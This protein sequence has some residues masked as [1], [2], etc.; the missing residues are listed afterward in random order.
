MSTLEQTARPQQGKPL[1]GDEILTNAIALADRVRKRNL[2][3][4]YDELRMLPADIVQE[5]REAGIMRM[6]MPRSWGG[7]EMTIM[8][9]ARVIEELAKADASIAWCSFIWAD[10]GVYPAYLDD[11][12]AR[13]LYPRLDM[14]TSGWVYPVGTAKRVT[15]GYEISGRWM[16]GSGINHCDWVVSGCLVDDVD[17]D[18]TIDR[19]RL[20]FVPPEEYEILDTW[21]T[22]GL[23][24]TGSTDY[25]CDKIFVPEERVGTFFNG[26]DREGPS[27][28]YPGVFLG[29]A[30][31]VPLGVAADALTQALRIMETKTD[32][33]S[34]PYRTLPRVQSALAE[35]RAMLGSARSYLYS[36]LEAQWAKLEADQPL[37]VEERADVW[38]ARTNAFQVGRQVVSQLYDLVGGSA[39]YTEKSPFD[40]H[41]RDMQTACQ[42]IIAQTKGWEW[43]GQLLLGVSGGHPML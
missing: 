32:G 3:A 24:G 30:A 10:S 26:C 39:V 21:Y 29:K 4:E 13:E 15:G 16:F 9:S 28:K 23:R 1:T 6:Q 8:E 27:W 19:W 25:R 36:S 17:S 41:L 7:P 35:A 42:H 38:L 14:A 37:T 22:T 34:G 5:V 20:M 2:V 18:R 33:L 40:R 31:G 11:E 43:V 12:V